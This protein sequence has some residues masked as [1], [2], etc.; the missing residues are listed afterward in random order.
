M[1]TATQTRSRRIILWVI[2][3]LAVLALVAT[4]GSMAY[5]KQ[6][7]G[8][9]L[10]GTTVMGKDVSGM[11]QA[12]ITKLL[13]GQDT[14]VKATIV[15]E[16]ESTAVPIEDLGV[17]LDPQA[18]AAAAVQRDASV[19]N[20]V[21]G[22]DHAVKP[23]L[24]MDR[25]VT[26][27]YASGLVPEGR[28]SAK[29]AEVTYDPENGSFSVTEAQ[30]GL[31]VDPE[32][33]V[34]TVRKGASG[35]KDFT[36][37]QEFTRM[38]PALSTE[39][40]EAAVKRTEAMLDKPMTVT[41]PNGRTFEISKQDRLHFVTVAPNAD[42]TDFETQVNADE[43]AAYVQ[44]MANEIE[45]SPKNGVTGV[46]GDGK[47]IK[48]LNEKVDGTS[49]T[50]VDE[51]SSE[52]VTAMQKGTEFSAT[53]TTKKV[54]AKDTTTVIEAEKKDEKKSDNAEKKKADEKKAD[55]KKAADKKSDDAKP[56]DKEST[57]DKP[58]LPAH[59]PKEAT[60]GD[61]WID[62]N[63]SNKTIT[64]YQGTQKVYGPIS[65][66]DGKPGNETATGE[67]TTYLRYDKQ[68]M[69]NEYKY[70]KGHPKYYYTK[71]VPYVQYFKGGYAIHGA[72]WRSSFGY[73]GSHGCINLPVQD[74]KWF[75]DWAP[76]GTKVVSHR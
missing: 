24:T 53:F 8:K 65:M 58:A 21:F 59:A 42:G 38:E 62:I 11:T 13:S 30:A 33:F 46:D 76:M 18:T 69:T 23:V 71:D 6:F 61:K 68:D 44:T 49:V 34:Q 39:K 1:S 55:E 36:I 37:T 67:F 3:A 45:V 64:A 63:L 14:G 54:P 25:K 51:V 72:P 15:A 56:E 31:G 40:A 19:G 9:A 16:G 17:T 48:V 50:N 20:V 29:N 60:S 10:P 28:E 5:A 73:A 27:D 41:G 32:Q 57:D 52:F 47:V 22:G 43:A 26:T 7:E 66:V 4:G 2:A 74:A 70:P 12:E 75:Y 35:M